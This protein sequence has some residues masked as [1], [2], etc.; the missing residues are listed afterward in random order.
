[1]S[2]NKNMSS[3][4]SAMSARIRSLETAVANHQFQEHELEDAPLV[5]LLMKPALDAGDELLLS[6]HLNCSK[7][8]PFELFETFHSTTA[9][10]RFAFTNVLSEVQ[11][12]FS[13]LK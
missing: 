12:T 9:H 5:K 3:F 11:R 1:M 6:S 10:Q 2:H 7:T 4:L 13:V 8:I